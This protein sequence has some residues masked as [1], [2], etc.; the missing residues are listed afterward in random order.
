MNTSLPFGFSPPH[1]LSGLGPNAS[2]LVGFSGGADSSALLSMLVDYSHETGARVCAAHVNH[3][4]RGD[5]ADRDEQFCR[6]TA[7]RLGIELFVCRRDVPAF[8]QQSGQG[9][10]AAARQ[11]R[12][13]FFDSIMEREGI[14]VLATA[15]NANDNLETQLFQLIRGCGLKGMCGIPQAR[16]TRFGVLIRPMLSMSRK[17]ILAYCTEKKL[18]YVTDSTNADTVYTRN[19]IRSQIIPLL[20][21]INEGAVENASRLS[22]SLRS[23]EL[24]LSGLADW[25]LEEMNE[26]ASFE[27]EKFLGSPPAVSNR[28][29]MALYGDVS[30]GGTLEYTHI[31]AIRRLCQAA[32]PHSS[33]SLPRGVDARIENKR[34][35]IVPHTPSAPPSE[36]FELV[37]KEGKNVISEINAEIIIGN[38]QNAINIYKNSILL[39]FDSAKICGNIIARERRAGDKIKINGMSKSLKKLLCDKK[40][41]LDVRYRLPIICDGSGILAVPFVAIRDG[42]EAKDKSNALVMRF[43]LNFC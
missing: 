40:I 1:V 34:L 42:A 18:D 39:Y 30:N 16:K 12:Y 29:L 27:L 6:E 21:Q 13:E 22:A 20:E 36:E 5:E 26:D 32:V 19:K 35:Y 10:E 43:T 3:M 4:I 7:E 41:P 28:A 2:V 37:L 14:P 38:S 17:E 8:A 25:F 11:I 15:H 9:T 31:N 24:C 23:D 33:V